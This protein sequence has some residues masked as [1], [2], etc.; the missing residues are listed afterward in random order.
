[1]LMADPQRSKRRAAKPADPAPAGVLYVRGVSAETIA[2]LDAWVAERRAEL[3]AAATDAATRRI[4]G[5][6]SRNDLLVDII[7]GAVKA[8]GAAKQ[9]TGA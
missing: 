4:A 9:E 8:H 7:E 3:S 1:M 2:A 6:L 5:S